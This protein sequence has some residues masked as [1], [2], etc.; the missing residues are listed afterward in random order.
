MYYKKWHELMKLVDEFYQAYHA[1]AEKYDHEIG[2]LRHAHRTTV[3][4]FPN[5][6]PSALHDDSYPLVPL[7]P[8]WG[9]THL[10]FLHP[11]EHY[12]TQMTYRRMHWCFIT[13]SC[14][15]KEWAYS[16]ALLSKK[17]LKQLNEMFATGEGAV[18]MNLSEGRVRKGLKF[19]E[20][21][22]EGY[23]HKSHSESRDFKKQ[24]S[25]GERGFK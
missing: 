20:E 4:A 16:D 13:F 19:H 12:L 14:H 25:Q 8:I 15:Q 22:G 18:H 5:Q 1:L 23:E 11:F 2:A 10:N 3:E 17:G 6:V 21:E 9:L 24:L 7:P